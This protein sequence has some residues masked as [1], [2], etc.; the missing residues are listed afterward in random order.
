[1]IRII[2]ACTACVFASP[3]NAAPPIFEFWG[4]PEACALEDKS[5]A[6]KSIELFASIDVGISLS[7]IDKDWK[8]SRNESHYRDLKLRSG[9]YDSGLLVGIPSGDRMLVVLKKANVRP[10]I[11]GNE[12]LEVFRADRKVAEFSLTGAKEF[13]P[14]FENCVESLTAH[15]RENDPFADK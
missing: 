9:Q 10:L 6:K 1:M 14:K 3:A 5:G 7:L 8:L 4:D 11:E 15:A 12:T 2:I 13:L